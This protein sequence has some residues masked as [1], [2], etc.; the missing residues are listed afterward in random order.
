MCD[1]RRHD[2]HDETPI[3]LSDVNMKRK[4]FFTVLWMLAFAAL[5]FL[6]AIAV[7]LPL[8]HSGRNL[9]AVIYLDPILQ[10]IFFVAP[11]IALWLGWRGRLPGTKRKKET[12]AA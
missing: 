1:V 4:A 3:Q 9:F 6:L 2:T 8:T 10:S 11:L 12:N 7:L 5:A